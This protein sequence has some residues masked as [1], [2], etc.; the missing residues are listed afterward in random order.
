M[1]KRLTRAELEV[2]WTRTA[3]V[4]GMHGP[5]IWGERCAVVQRMLDLPH[6]GDN[7][8]L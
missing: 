3:F 7:G 4:A 1:G 5:F 6:A 2:E 8:Y